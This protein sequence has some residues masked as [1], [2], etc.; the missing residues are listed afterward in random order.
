MSKFQS[1]EHRDKI[2]ASRKKSGWFKDVKK[3]KK[4]MS[5][6]RK[7]KKHPLYGKHHSQET[8]EKMSKANK[9]KTAWNKGKP[10]K[11]RGAK[12]HLWKGGISFESYSVDWTKTLKRSIRERDKYTC[13]VCGK[14]QEDRALDVHHI[15]YDKKNCNPTNLVAL[16]VSCHR[17][18]NYR[19]DY[20]TKY[21][22]KE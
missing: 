18:T 11:I 12:S 17:K 13:K 16:C 15:D 2:N 4:I 22:I 6:Q 5:E 21:F 14:Q 3:T 1:K 7:G 9:G 8:R 10:S 20:W 19:R